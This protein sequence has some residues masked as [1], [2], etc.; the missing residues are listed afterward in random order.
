MA[1]FSTRCGHVCSRASESESRRRNTTKVVRHF[2]DV[3]NLEGNEQR[4]ASNDS[5]DENARPETMV[6]VPDSHPQYVDESIVNACCIN[7]LETLAPSSKSKWTLAQL[8]SNA[9]FEKEGYI[10]MTKA[11]YM[12]HL[13]CCDERLHRH[14]KAEPTMARSVRRRAY[15]SFAKT[16]SEA[17]LSHILNLIF[18]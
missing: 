12:A 5:Q 1:F 10:A 15:Q 3:F 9:Q 17:G 16:T 4:E 2:K 8:V 18:V 11:K 7:L 6:R 14:H 13:V